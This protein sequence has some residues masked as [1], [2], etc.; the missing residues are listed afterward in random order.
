MVDL[1]DVK[2]DYNKLVFACEGEP[3]RVVS[4][5][6]LEEPNGDAYLEYFA[7]FATYEADVARYYE[8]KVDARNS[9]SPT[10]TIELPGTP[11]LMEPVKIVGRTSK[12][13]YSGLMA[14]YRQLEEEH[15]Y[16]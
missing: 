7:R 8:A 14:E 10:Y 13:S 12:L 16:L 2:P 1:P 4:I 15:R 9:G 3:I 11:F 5:G 6:A